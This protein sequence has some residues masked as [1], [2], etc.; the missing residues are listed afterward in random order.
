MKA[1]LLTAFRSLKDRHNYI[2]T[3]ELENRKSEVDA[4]RVLRWK[5]RTFHQVFFAPGIPDVLTYQE[6]EAVD[7]ADDAVVPVP[8]DWPYPE[9]HE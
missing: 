1:I 7:L 8:A 4:Q 9:K 2:G 5:G 6:V 3:T